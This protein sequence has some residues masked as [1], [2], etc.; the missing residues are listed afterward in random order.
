LYR[1]IEFTSTIRLGRET[2]HGHRLTVDCVKPDGGSIHTDAHPVT[3]SVAGLLPASTAEQRI[4][5]GDALGQCM[6][7]PPVLDAFRETISHLG[8]GIGVRIRLLCDDV[9]AHWPWELMRIEVPPFKTRRFLF[10]DPRF[11]LMRTFISKQPV[12]SPRERPK[13]TILVAD[14]TGVL[15]DRKLVPDFPAGLPA[16]LGIELLGLDRP[17][18]TSIDET[19]EKINDGQ[20]SLDI[21][22][23][24]GHGLAAHNGQAG[25]LVVYREG[26]DR[27]APNYRADE[28]AAQLA[29]AGTS[30]AFINA[31]YTA[32]QDA[33]DDGPSV[34]HVLADLVPVVVAM[35]GDIADRAATGFAD[36]FY[37]LLL[38]GS[39][40]DEAVSQGRLAVEESL[41][42]W[43]SIVLYS[44]A[45]TGR[46]LEPVAA[47]PEPVP[48]VARVPLTLDGIRRWAM[49]GGGR[50]YWQLLPGEP[51]PELRRVDSETDADISN[52]GLLTAS[53]ALSSDARVAAQVHEG[54][55]EVAWVDRVRPRL[56][57]WP[58]SFELPFS[59][60]QARLL[61]VAVDY[62]DQVT[63]LISTDQ[64][65]YRIAASPASSLNVTEIF[66]A[67][68]RCAAI[69]AGTMFTVDGA[70]QLRGRVLNLRRQGIA[71]ISSL[72]AARSGGHALYAIVGRDS[73]GE[74]IVAQYGEPDLV[75]MLP[76]CAADEVAV[77]R[78]LSRRHAPDQVLVAVGG[79]IER[80]RAGA[81]T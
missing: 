68:T 8:T 80:L 9:I 60:P 37:D 62:G 23:F 27:G 29:R 3:S 17:T 81:G 31:C 72:D 52:L 54:R 12:D 64:A 49:I 58:Q 70:G 79:H 30:L 34:A 26:G 2:K 41:P 1:Y 51:G 39:T 47:V 28:L 21:F 63:C 71:E 7:P 48:P 42:H 46:F 76:G 50:G 33:P 59:G 14:A 25:A 13:L 10:R 22:H 18:G 43:S 24:T 16:D 57:R 53:V 11:S 55:L 73:A 32:G 4:A 40:V 75:D 5:L 66:D 45:R 65:T 61:A 78:P 19:I 20:D 6:F 38:R 56:D 44:R 67:P 69:L 15:P 77:V 35:R 36:V 74:P